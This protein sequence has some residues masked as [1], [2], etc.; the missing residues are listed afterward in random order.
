[1]DPIVAEPNH[2]PLDDGG[3]FRGSRTGK[4]QSWFGLKRHVKRLM[5]API[6][7]AVLR[8]VVGA[9]PRL[10]SGRLPAPNGLG[11]V[12]GIVGDTTFV[13]VRPDRCENAKDLYWGQGRRTRAEDVLSLE[14]V[15]RLAVD[16]DVFLD[17]GSYTGLF[18]LATT[19]VDPQLRAHAFDIVPSVV[20][21]LKANL[22]RN[23]V[24]DRVEVHEEGVGTPGTTMRVPVAEGGSSLPSF[25]SSRMHFDDGVS[26][27]FRSLDS[28]IGA[29]PADARVVM[30]IDVEGTEDR[31]FRDGQDFLGRF[32][33]DML[34]EVLQGVADVEAL[35]ELLAPHGFSVYLVRER[36][37]RW[38]PR[39]QP[40]EGFR[41]WLITPKD[42]E[43]LASM[44]FTVSGRADR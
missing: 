40:D 18:T 4:R 6:P 21:T 29:L 12:T 16:A 24:S 33:P 39:I 34:C 13:M 10:R 30:K 9:V 19:A 20:A 32:R 3:D 23:G 31:I 36:D 43:T 27:E 44:G 8:T 28:M 17:I 25:Y 2:E 1:V 41:D 38:A 37:L 15:A 22:E 7:H 14:V 5:G 42:P 11:E 35:Q 26:I